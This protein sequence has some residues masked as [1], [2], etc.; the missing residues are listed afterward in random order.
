MIA[1]NLAC[2]DGKP[3]R[4]RIRTMSRFIRHLCAVCVAAW[5]CLAAAPVAAHDGPHGPEVLARVTRTVVSGSHLDVEL[6]VTGLG[7][8]LVLSDIA[9]PEADVR[10]DGPVSVTFAQDVTV[11]AT[12]TFAG[13]P[14]SIFTLMLDFGVA[15]Q[16][17]VTVIPG[18]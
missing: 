2:R 5:A 18:F 16:G 15:G 7:G 17:A 1:K 14:P 12:L 13:S 6:V 10:F 9:V 11:S 4:P 8:P 3:G